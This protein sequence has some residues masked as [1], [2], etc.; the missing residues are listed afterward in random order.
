MTTL[1][2]LFGFLVGVKALG[3]GFQLLGSATLELI[4]SA[5]AN[6]FVSLVVGILATTV[7]QSSSVTTSM[8]VGL[9]ASPE[10]PLP[11]ANAVPM[12][13]G[14]N[15]GTTVTATLVSLAHVGRSDE[16]ERAFPIAVCHD[17]F[18]YVTVLV[19]LPLELLTGYLQQSAIAIGQLLEEVGGIDYESPF[20]HM[21]SAT[22]EPIKQLIA[23][24]FTASQLQGVALIVVGG[25]TIFA[26]LFLIVKVMR[27]VVRT[28]VERMV[29]NVLGSSAVLAILVGAAVTVMVQSSS[30]TTSLLVPLGAAGV[31]RLEQ[32]LPITIGANV[33]TTVTAL[34]A[35]LAGSGVNRMYGLEIALVHLLFNLT[36]MI[37]I[38]PLAVIRSIPLKSA[39]YLTKLALRSPRLTLFF[40][41]AL[42]Y[43]LPALLL[44]LDRVIG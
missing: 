7:M 31:L 42:F 41:A 25:G 4:F 6:P 22:L 18:N 23:F 39:R 17:L 11:L 32:A 13:M 44:F 12:I 36:G 8:I 33:G 9:V 14:A 34:F 19:L 29:A 5:T 37:L 27:S 28:K 38:Y 16:F 20:S 30:I 24:V 3:D 43:G 26:T 2:L 10:S 1:L 35:A 21:I 15:I 40:V